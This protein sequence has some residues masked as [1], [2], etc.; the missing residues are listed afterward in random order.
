MHAL[1]V[2]LFMGKLGRGKGGCKSAL[3]K[4]IKGARETPK[5]LKTPCILREIYVVFYIP[6]QK[7]QKGKK[8]EKRRIFIFT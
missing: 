4:K 8:K 5:F 2:R 3:S 1:L 7:K 6:P